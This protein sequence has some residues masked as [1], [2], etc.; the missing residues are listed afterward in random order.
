MSSSALTSTLNTNSEYPASLPPAKLNYGSKVYRRTARAMFAGGFATF[1][2]L[3]CVQPLLPQF[4]REFQISAAVASGA[5]S[6]STATMALMLIP[7]SILAD[8]YGRR[9]VMS[10]SLG[11][12]SLFL[13]GCALAGNFTQLLVLRTLIGFTLAGLPAVAMTY[14]S[15][16]IETGSLGRALGLYIAGNALGGMCGRLI[17]GVL[18]EWG[19]WRFSLGGLGILSVLATL[20]FSRNLPPSRHFTRV[21]AD[22]R[23]M[24]KSA[25]HLIG[26][27]G[28]PWL[29][30]CGFLVMG[31]FVS[32]YNVLGYRLESAPFNLSP[33]EEGLIFTLYVI[34]MCGSTWAG[35]LADRVGRRNVLWIMVV[36]ALA[37]LLL[38]LTQVLPPLVAGIA[39]FTFGFFGTHSVAS[40]WIGMRAGHDKA[41]ASAL[42]LSS[43]Y[44]GASV[45][46]AVSGMMWRL[47]A[48]PGVV[49]LLT[50]A[51][52]LC[53]AAALY[54]RKL[55]PLH[56]P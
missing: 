12:S 23:R 29:F 11:L 41:L 42:Y 36:I 37:G 20:D 13:I 48:W 18:C 9:T 8:R 14:L 46:G 50:V 6:T 19:S 43:Y 22:T 51:L 21:K 44:L 32:M 53:L 4:S 38:T 56:T 16:E 31:C 10:L 34:G 49:A 2:T 5:V 52:L 45:L 39:I 24:V 40:S 54:L 28:L 7:A 17:A 35:K 27:A 1:S 30:L 15:E 25:R 33:A 3:Y 47:A 26:D 55:P